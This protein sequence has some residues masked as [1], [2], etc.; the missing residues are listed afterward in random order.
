MHE[1]STRVSRSVELCK[2]RTF[3]SSDDLW[4]KRTRACIEATASLVCCA[5]ANVAWFGGIP[6]LLGDIGCFEKIRELSLAGKDELFVIRWT[7]LS[8]VAIQ[9]ILEHKTMQDCARRAICR[10]SRDPGN[11]EKDTLANAQKIDETLQK[12]KGHLIWLNGV[13][14][15][16]EDLA[17]V[18]EILRTHESQI[19]E[20]E[21]INIE[22]DSLHWVNYGIILMHNAINFHSHQITSQIPGVLDDLDLSPFPF[23]HFVELSR[24]PR[25]LQFIRPKQMLESMCSPATTLRNILEGQGA[26]D[27]YNGLLK[28]LREFRFQSG[29][30]GDEMQRQFWRLQDLRDGGG[31]G[32]TVEL[33]FITLL[34]L[35]SASSSNESYNALYTGTFQA[36][37]SDWSKHKHS[38]G[39]QML[40][41]DIAMSRRWEFDT[42]YPDYI[43]DKF[44]LLL[45]NI[46]KGQTGPH[47]NKARQQLESF[48]L[49]S[50]KGF[51]ERVFRVLTPGQAQS[52]AS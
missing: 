10:V 6:K 51:V 50:P 24:D 19:S 8:L 27:A 14:P 5:N 48:G 45:G 22:A 4:R 26:V 13:L 20:L 29:W 46:F 33:F 52:L 38:L 25:E 9:Q 3:F 41:L 32:F 49:Y 34:Q 47:I 39:T 11:H 43:V 30:Q 7:C 36:I 35:L 12:V 18:V 16:T 40:L 15:E 31:L 1:L 44:L 28:D 17:E 42:Q 23:S 2:D 21:Q 37:T